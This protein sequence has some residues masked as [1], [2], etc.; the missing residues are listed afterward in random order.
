MREIK[1]KITT[2]E[3]IV[4]RE[5]KGK[6]LVILTHEEYKQKVNTFIQDKQFTLINNNPTQ[7]YQKI[8]KQTLKQCNDIIPKE[9]IWKY[10]NMNPIAPNLHATIKLHKPG[11]PIRP[12]INWKNAPAYKLAI[13][14]TNTLQNYLHLPYTYN[15]HNSVHLI[16]DLNTIELNKNIRMF[17]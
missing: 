15:I 1:E 12:V 14:L 9:N 8:I 10:R 6:T 5:D 11:T 4:K 17:L 2:N 7:H 16:T 3:L 13:Q